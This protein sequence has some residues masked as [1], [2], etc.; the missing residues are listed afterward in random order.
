[1][2]FFQ[3]F[4][5]LELNSVARVSFENEELCL[6]KRVFHD[7]Y[8]LTISS[9]IRKSEGYIPPKTRMLLDRQFQSSVCLGKESL[10]VNQEGDIILVLNESCDELSL[11]TVQ[12]ILNKFLML[13]EVWRERIDDLFEQ[14]TIYAKR[15]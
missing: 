15:T 7:H 11:K 3:V 13:M 5:N 4:S 1:M 2:T 6:K 10:F 9:V 14:D 8:M 12:S